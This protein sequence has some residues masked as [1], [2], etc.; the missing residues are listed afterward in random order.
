MQE[1]DEGPPLGPELEKAVS[2]LLE[3]VR[4]EPISPRLRELAG[5]LAQ[6]LEK[7]RG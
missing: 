2:E 3:Q 5:R 7:P 4:S 6:A 1:N